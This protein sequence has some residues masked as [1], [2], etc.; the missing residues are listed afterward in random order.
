MQ[1]LH[2]ISAFQ[3][4]GSVVALGT[5]DGVHLGH[6]AL[7]AR[8]I[9]LARGLGLPVFGRVQRR[10]QQLRH[11]GGDVQREGDHRDHDRRDAFLGEYA[12]VQEEQQQQNRRPRSTA[13]YT[14]A[15]PQA[16]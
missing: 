9:Q 5:F 7:I 3:G 2:E 15:M 11:M 16:T 6:A 12:V 1:I 13:M 14:K 10:T 8:T 4:E